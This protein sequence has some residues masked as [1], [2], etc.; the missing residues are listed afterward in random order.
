MPIG[1]AEVPWSG[2]R[3]AATVPHS[4]GKINMK[5]RAAP[6]QEASASARSVVNRCSRR[7][8]SRDW[9]ACQLCRVLLLTTPR[10]SGRIQLLVP[11]NS[12]TRRQT[13]RCKRL[14][15]SRTQ[16]N[17]RQNP[18]FVYYR[19]WTSHLGCM[20]YGVNVPFRSALTPASFPRQQGQPA[21]DARS[22]HRSRPRITS[23]LQFQISAGE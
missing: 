20:R 3:E 12:R 23:G 10:T 14:T 15:I 22:T 13:I 17:I 18:K 4:K 16:T 1:P 21:V 8:D 2:V 7:R 6:R 19:I 9:P 11:K 5:W